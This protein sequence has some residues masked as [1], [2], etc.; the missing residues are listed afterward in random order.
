MGVTLAAVDNLFPLT[1]WRYR[2]SEDGLNEGLLSEIK[3]RRAAEKGIPNSNR[4]GWQS[5]RDLFT[6]TEAS[7]AKLVRIISEVVVK[8]LHSLDPD[9][10][11]AA[12]RVTMNGWVNINPPGG[13]NAPHQHTDALL[14]GVYYIAVPSG[15]SDA[16][17]AIE[18][19]SPHAVRQLGG[20]IKAPLFAERRRVHPEVGDLLLFPGQ[21]PHWVHP[22][23]SGKDRV[24][25]AFNA[26]VGRRLA[27]A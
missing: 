2:I 20:L 21:L 5:E 10:D 27:E 17:G 11:R 18:F 19:L 6:R 22:N 15:K 13:Y 9:L 24:T 14:S 8:T 4:R 3:K 7:H 23:D 25:I 12:I 1:L 26:I 16:G